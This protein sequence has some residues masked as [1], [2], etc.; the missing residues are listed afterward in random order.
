MNIIMYI[1]MNIIRSKMYIIMNVIMNIIM[2]IIRS[3]V[4][5]FV[6][7]MMDYASK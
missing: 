2:Y 4:M 7:T 1:I 5:N 6:Q 3:K